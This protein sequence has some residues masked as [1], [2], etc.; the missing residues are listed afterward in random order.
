[1][2]KWNS[3]LGFLN[4]FWSYLKS[5]PGILVWLMLGLIAYFSVQIRLINLPSLIDVTTGEPVPLGND[6][7]IFYRYAKYVVENG[8]LMVTDMLRYF[9]TGFSGM[10]E[11]KVLSYV[12]AYFYKFLNFFDSNISF[13]YVVA[14]Y[15][16]AAFV[17]SLIVFFILLKKVF[18]VRV[19]LL[20]SIFLAFLPAYLSRTIAG[21]AD[22]EALAM[23][24]IYLAFYLI[25]KIMESS[26]PSKGYTYAVL[27]AVNVAILWLVWG[28]VVYVLLT[29]GAFL[30]L[31]VMFG[32]L[33]NNQLKYFTV[34]V[35][36]L[37]IAYRIAFPSRGNLVVLFRS[38]INFIAPMLLALAVGWG[39]KLIDFSPL[40]KIATKYKIPSQVLTLGLVTVIGLALFAL[41]FSPSLLYSKIV[42]TVPLLVNPNSSDRLLQTVMEASQTYFYDNY[43]TLFGWSMLLAAMAGSVLL[44][45]VAFAF[46]AKDRKKLTIAYAIFL[47]TFTM[48]RYSPN[49]VLFD[50]ESIISLTIFLGGLVAFA[51][52]FIFVIYKYLREPAKDAVDFTKNH[53]FY[54]LMI[55]FFLITLLGA[56]TAGRL[57]FVLSPT[58]S[59]MA[60]VAILALL[61]LAWSF[62]D[63]LY[64]YSSVVLI[65]V[66]LV[67]VINLQ[68]SS[69][70]FAAVDQDLSF[71]TQW[72]E[73]M[74]WVRE[75]T[76]EDAVF[77]SWWD[78]G[79]WIQAK[80]ER[81]T[82]SDGGNAVGNVN[83]D[84]ARNIF[85]AQNESVV[86]ES[87][88]NYGADNL[89]IS[90]EYLFIYDVIS[91][92]G[93]DEN[94]DRKSSLQLS[95]NV[96]SA[97]FS[98]DNVTYL[99]FAG[100]DVFDVDITIDN[101]L[102]PAEYT[103]IN[104][105][106]MPIYTDEENNVVE[107]GIAEIV[108]SYN[109]NVARVPVSCTF[110]D[111]ELIEYEGE[112]LVDVCLM[113]VPEIYGEGLV[114]P[115]G[116]VVY[117]PSKAVDSTI[118]QMYL[119]GQDYEG[120]ELVYS[121][122]EKYPFYFSEGLFYGPIKIWKVSS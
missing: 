13:D 61:K 122:E 51:L 73:G 104:G 86:L 54:L 33:S 106:V 77:A 110:Y 95:R 35:F 64:K 103:K 118:V 57:L 100:S 84:T 12:L 20:A 42:E 89:L 87:L 112:V 111:G 17:V 97:A 63:A 26:S 21:F 8:S 28:G 52:Y 59:M 48:S 56:R 36:V 37:L 34:F 49:S 119:L 16:V 67:L 81:A 85:V 121:D 98:E 109:D 58:I 96:P 23:I 32:K 69:S 31:L 78:Y 3:A 91:F 65:L 75:N 15:S 6:P 101:V 72:Q 46:L 5:F 4:K 18:S 44:F 19:A 22:K 115:L 70:V 74:E 43:V 90:S 117:V 47:L 102:F 7:F 29:F 10:E 108:L 83:Y 50:G 105:F 66:G 94:F 99:V 30:F 116:G 113:V 62:K 68:I 80:G 93:S 60:A 38:T 92:I 2:V 88:E 24:L 55:L 76:S 114:D 53:A 9:P 11:F 1:M 107:V 40:H 39:S 27:A 79:Y 45:Y 41:F 120:L 82:L 71:N 25:I 14:V